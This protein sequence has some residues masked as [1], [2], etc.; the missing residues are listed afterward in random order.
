MKNL[1]PD[2]V[3]I[4]VDLIRDYNK[5]NKAYWD[6]LRKYPEAARTRLG[7]DENLNFYKER[8]ISREILGNELELAIGE[9]KP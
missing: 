1:T 2:D 3:E 5:G 8:G 6:I 4:L 7:C 9:K